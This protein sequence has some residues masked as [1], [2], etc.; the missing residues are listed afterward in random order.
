M[1]A[2]AILTQ[3]ASVA[4]G[5]DMWEDPEFMRSTRPGEDP[6]ASSPAAGP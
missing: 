4:T 3:M 5:D 2:I 6:T 1:N